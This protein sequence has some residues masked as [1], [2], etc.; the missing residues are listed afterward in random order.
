[1]T[2]KT[3]IVLGV[4]TLKKI[5]ELLP[6]NYSVALM[7]NNTVFP[8]QTF[9]VNDDYEEIELKWQDLD[10]REGRKHIDH[11]DDIDDIKRIISELQEENEQLKQQLK[12]LQE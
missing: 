3:P 5:L 1:M 6:H 9:E 2:E 11:I 4:D 10:Y 12:E 7:I 8:A